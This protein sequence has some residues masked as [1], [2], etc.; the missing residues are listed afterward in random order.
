MMIIMVQCMKRSSRSLHFAASDLRAWIR[1]GRHD[2][3]PVM[4]GITIWVKRSS[5]WM[6][7]GHCGRSVA[8]STC[9]RRGQV[10]V[11]EVYVIRR[12]RATPWPFHHVIGSFNSSL[13]TDVAPQ[14]VNATVERRS[15]SV[16][17]S[18][19]QH[20]SFKLDTTADGVY[21]LLPQWA[22]LGYYASKAPALASDHPPE[23]PN[24]V[25]PSNLFSAPPW[26][27]RRCQL[28]A[29]QFKLLWLVF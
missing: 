15:D 25:F 2:S 28:S 16:P 4:C 7:M 26:T 5:P 17:L 6:S 18:G 19:R 22:P 14:L 3:C 29:G 10:A 1:A 12:D 11:V 13:V 9:R 21:K 20:T 24:F 27:P 23:P 8:S